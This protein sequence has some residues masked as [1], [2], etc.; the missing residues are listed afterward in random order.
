MALQTHKADQS[1]PKPHYGFRLSIPCLPCLDLSEDW[2]QGKR[3]TTDKV[4]F[5][6]VQCLACCIILLLLWIR[7]INFAGLVYGK[8]MENPQLPFTRGSCKFLRIYNTIQVWES[9]TIV[10]EFSLGGHGWWC[11][12]FRGITSHI[13]CRVFGHH[14]DSREARLGTGLSTKLTGKQRKQGVELQTASAKL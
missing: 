10:V 2:T 12:L 4:Q 8:I 14:T 7:C 13:P 5:N 3:D 1:R 9:Q 11:H 6:Q